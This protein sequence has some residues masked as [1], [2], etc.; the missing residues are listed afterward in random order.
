MACKITFNNPISGVNHT[1]LIGYLL[2][3]AGVSNEDAIKEISR[4]SNISRG[5]TEW[6]SLYAGVEP[7]DFKEL[8]VNES[9][10][11]LKKQGKLNHIQWMLDV[12]D[13]YDKQGL[14]LD[15]EFTLDQ[16][17]KLLSDIEY[18][19]KAS[20][21]TF[22]LEE[23]EGDTKVDKGGTKLYKLYPTQGSYGNKITLKNKLNR[24]LEKSR[25]FSQLQKFKKFSEILDFPN[26]SITDTVD[27]ILNHPE[28]S[29]ETKKLFRDI[30]PFLGLNPN[31]KLAV[32]ETQSYVQEEKGLSKIQKLFN[33]Y[34]SNPGSYNY[35]TNTIDLYLREAS[36]NTIEDVAKT[37]L[38]EAQH[39]V[40]VGALLNPTT[41]AEKDLA[42]TLNAAYEQYRH[43]LDEETFKDINYYG[44]SDPFEFAVAF[45]SNP[46]FRDIIKN[47]E[48][49]KPFYQKVVDAFTNFFKSIFKPTSNIVGDVT[50]ESIQK[51]LDNYFDELSK[52]Q[53]LN[54]EITYNEKQTVFNSVVTPEAHQRFQSKFSTPE[55]YRT[56]IRQVLDS[57]NI[58]WSKVVQEAQAINLNMD[59]LVNIQE[60]YSQ[61]SEGD[62]KKSIE[63][64]Y[65]FLHETALY[66]RS[67]ERSLDYLTVNKTVS[68]AE[69]FKRTYHARELGQLFLDYIADVE[70]EFGQDK[71]IGT[72]LESPVKNIRA[73]A[74]SLVSKYT[75][76]ASQAIATMLAKEFEK[77]T[78][79]L[80]QQIEK[81]ITQ[82]EAVKDAAIRSNNQNLLRQTQNKINQ[83][84]EQ[85]KQIATSENIKKAL[86]G[87]VKDVSQISL[88]LESAALTGNIITGTVAGFISNMFDNAAAEAIGI[89]VKG[90]QIGVKLENYLKSSNKAGV[91][92]T[93]YTIAQAYTPFI[94]KKIILEIKNNEL[95]ERETY[96]LISEMDEIEYLNDKTR[97]K[98]DIKRLE[99]DPN[100]T[101][102][103]RNKIKQKQADLDILQDTYEESKY[104]EEYYRVQNLLSD[105]AKNVRDE[106]LAEM[107][108]IR[109][110]AV[111]I[112]Q[113][114]EVLD[115]L[116]ILK[117]RLTQL[118]SDFDEFGKIKD[119]EGLR[120]AKNIRDWKKERNA[121]ELI[122][123][124]I[125]PEHRELFDIKFK[126]YE[127]AVSLSKSEY[128][129]AKA[130]NSNDVEFYLNK[131]KQKEKEFDT[132]LKNNAVRKIDKAF[133]AERAL[134]LSRI[135]AI[136][137]KYRSQED[138]A[139]ISELY[140]QLFALLK[141][142]KNEDGFYE[143]SKVIEEKSKEGDKDINIALRVKELENKIEN[144]RDE[145][146]DKTEISDNDKAE[147]SNLFSRLSA[148]QEKVNT[149]D[150]DKVLENK[151]AEIRAK[152]VARKQGLTRQAIEAMVT[153]ELQ[154][155]DWFKENH[156]LVSKYNEELG[157]S[158]QVYEPIFYWRTTQ[159]KDKK[160]ITY[161]NPSFRWYTYKV[162]D[163]Y[164][165][166]NKQS[167]KT[168]KR[169]ALKRDQTKYKNQAYSKLNPTE[170]EILNDMIEFYTELNQGLPY[171]LTRGLEIPNKEKE[172]LEGLGDRKVGTLRAQIQG[173]G[174]SIINEMTFRQDEDLGSAEDTGS[175]LNKAQ[176]RLYLRYSRPIN[177]DNIDSVSLN[178]LNSFVQFGADAA[179][180]KQAYKNLSYIYGIQ[181]VLEKQMPDTN[182]RKVV[183][184]MLERR[185]NG[186]TTKT[187]TNN[188]LVNATEWGVNKAISLG[189][190]MSLSLR[191]PSTIKNAAAGTANIYIQAD[192]YGLSRADISRGFVNVSKHVA[193]LFRSY[194]E[195][196]IENEYIQ[197]VKYFNIMPEDHLSNAG[198]RIFNSKFDVASKQ[199]NPLKYLSFLRN[200]GEFEMRA[201]VAEAL[202]RKYLIEHTDGKVRPI[203]DSFELKD[204]VLQPMSTVENIE[205]FE[206]TV[207]H[208]RGEL[209]IINSYIHGSY[210][211]MD[212]GE[213]TRYTLGRVMGYMK[214]WLVMQTMRRFG[215]RS[216]SHRA[217]VESQGFYRTL[218]QAMGLFVGNRSLTNT[219]GLLTTRE[220]NEVIAAGYDT[221][222]LAIMMAISNVIGALVYS[223]DDEDEDH[224]LAYFLLYN[225]LQIE[226]ELATLHPIAGPVSIAYSRFYN[227]PDGKS[228]P[229]YYLEKTFILP[230]R[231]VTDLLKLSYQMV[232]PFDD[233]DMFDEYVPRSRSGKI[234]NPNRYPPNPTLKGLNEITARSMRLFGLDASWNYSFGSSSEYL[235]RVYHNYN[236]RWFLSSLDKDLSSVKR[237]IN[238]YKKEIKSIERQLDYTDDEETKDSLREISS[239]LQRKIEER[240]IELETLKDFPT[241][242][243]IQ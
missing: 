125:I 212:K 46:I 140:D 233:I 114:D 184:N 180:F 194:I 48:K 126:Q 239:K 214:G 122:Q 147:L 156:R 118:E 230:F 15:H 74:N 22:L 149:P 154:K 129:Q 89:E 201:A 19:E 106:I 158:T 102:A 65:D 6:H 234:L 148:M 8:S 33:L 177:K 30:L 195:D 232:N 60:L 240:K 17:T 207:Q 12:Q 39:S 57:D 49:T 27:K 20:N 113:T 155:T 99:N 119:E 37:I 138:S 115:K 198:K 178:L 18:S 84:K 242:D 228:A 5:N 164:I 67:L 181:D 29:D 53:K 153:Q 16:I 199:Y 94:E 121:N 117:V 145:L 208:F 152:V 189:A 213:Y 71:I 187:W 160:Y 112:E 61:I 43:L 227:N 161:N 159:P 73:L 82:L 202:S 191:L 225:M 186:Q 36:V 116:T 241:E 34:G 51:S 193:P 68:D 11:L 10:D 209:N 151:K 243:Y 124:E 172:G 32:K 35:V 88:Y 45:M 81:N 192:M 179:R 136:Q 144:L 63:S 132:W 204:G 62:I 105:E 131:Y 236:E 38:H 133:Y 223:D 96:V 64:Y 203:M 4:L 83:E 206:K 59:S 165:N 1:S 134:V 2:T 101:E 98:F 100:Q 221:L 130:A 97:I 41:Q 40:T 141:S 210:G 170:K 200:F 28:V 169:I 93:G 143:G 146:A 25:P 23:L 75:L 176:R 222:S 69:L 183:N 127:E 238:S 3:S 108:A 220:K 137:D 111:E 77:P 90:K 174:Q 197:K 80:K 211:Y 163:K 135:N 218:L 139:P 142:Y 103:I 120:I 42:K 47:N 95:V 185:L 190:S 92:T 162:N 76:N 219:W 224:M 54:R 171:T 167:F 226:D 104:T 14:S 70:A 13:V 235:F 56:I 26:P 91:I 66:L 166:K 7:G 150:Y 87:K 31:L 107:K 24:E 188:K 85:L 21:F 231:S 237:D 182:I 168:N 216:I 79:K 86:K 50:V 109:I 44:F 55:E 229:V 72:L 123:Y 217:G 157:S 215:R 173:V 58:S 110:S 128:E 78:G 52:T 175:V 9:R 205:D 196:G